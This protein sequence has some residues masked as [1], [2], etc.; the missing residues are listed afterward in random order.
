MAIIKNRGYGFNLAK[1]V[2]ATAKDLWLR[3]K[4][5]TA[6][7]VLAQLK[8]GLKEKDSK[9]T[10]KNV[11]LALNKLCCGEMTAPLIKQGEEYIVIREKMLAPF[12][13]LPP[14]RRKRKSI[15]SLINATEPKKKKT[16]ISRAMDK[17]TY[18][19]LYGCFGVAEVI[20]KGGA[21]VY[22]KRVVNTVRRKLQIYIAHHKPDR[23]EL[24]TWLRH[25]V[26]ENTYRLRKQSTQIGIIHALQ[27][28]DYN[29]KDIYGILSDTYGSIAKGHT[30]EDTILRENAYNRRK[31]LAK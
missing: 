30:I 27:G 6:A 12:V 22:N 21:C 26:K 3:E 19:T 15:Q 14:P 7:N 24:T 29:Y 5:I 1:S 16:S 18:R 9:L 25:F 2:E 23:I 28:S 4:E 17:E 13:D 31:S 10:N 11:A 8:V 20:G